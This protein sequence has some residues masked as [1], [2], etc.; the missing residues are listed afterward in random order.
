LWRQKLLWWVGG[1]SHEGNKPM[2]KIDRIVEVLL[3]SEEYISDGYVYYCD[4]VIETLKKIAVAIL[5]VMEE[6]YE[7]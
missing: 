4:D 5:K 7:S 3:D 6:K 2:T 1:E